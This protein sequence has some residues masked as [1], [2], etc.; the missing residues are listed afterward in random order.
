[1][2]T[3]LGLMDTQPTYLDLASQWVS[4]RDTNRAGSVCI[5]E[6]K[7]LIQV[8]MRKWIVVSDDSLYIRPVHEKVGAWR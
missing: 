2:I 5:I 8:L 3:K 7:S 1:M 6:C 4:P